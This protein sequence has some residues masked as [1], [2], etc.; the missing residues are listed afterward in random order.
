VLAPW[1]SATTV[2]DRAG[3]IAPAALRL[4]APA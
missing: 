3:R 4:L 1:R 2:F